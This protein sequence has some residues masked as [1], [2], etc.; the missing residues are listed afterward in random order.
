MM[1]S[2]KFGLDPIGIY[3]ILQAP[4]T[5][6]AVA[7]NESRIL[8]VDDEEFSLRAYRRTF[9]DTYDMLT[10]SSG[11]DALKLL[12]T[13]AVDFVVVDHQMPGMDGLELIAQIKALKPTLPCLLVTAH[14]T[15]QDVMDAARSG[16][17]TIVIKAPW[18]KD[19]L[20]RWL[21]QMSRITVMQRA[22][23]DLKAWHK[24]TT[25][26]LPGRQR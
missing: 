5:G 4:G 13:E 9:G 6:A 17:V 22:V 19:E 23:G 10:A 15:R 16:Q 18:K 26:P 8:F 24:R 3:A 12:R 1:A 25:T 2:Q 7:E 14:H 21:A 11:L 20:G